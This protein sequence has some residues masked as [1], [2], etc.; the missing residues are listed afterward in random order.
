MNHRIQ[1]LVYCQI[2]AWFV[3]WTNVCDLPATALKQHCFCQVPIKRN[4]NS[5]RR[6]L[7]AYTFSVW[8]PCQVL[9]VVCVT[10]W[11]CL[12]VSFSHERDHQ[13]TVG[14]QPVAGLYGVDRRGCCRFV[15]SLSN[16]TTFGGH[17]QIDKN[18]NNFGGAPILNIGCSTYPRP[19]SFWCLW[20]GIVC[21]N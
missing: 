18:K 7:S 20:K 9:H 14:K 6:A 15:R 21:Q 2:I 10:I 3:R 11:R 4:T 1:V 5:R 13:S 8:D 17:Q 12:Q 16:C 19:H